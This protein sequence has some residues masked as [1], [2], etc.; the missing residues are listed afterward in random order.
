[1]LDELRKLYSEIHVKILT[2][3][4]LMVTIVVPIVSIR[5]FNAIESADSSNI[6]KGTE[7]VRIIKDRYEDYKGELSIDTLNR[8][9]NYYQSEPSEDLAYVDSSIRYPG[10]IS[11]LMDAYSSIIPGEGIHLNDLK[12]ADDFYSR[13]TV[14]IMG[15]LNHSNDTYEPWE[16]DVILEK[17]ESI[18]TPFNIDFS[19]QWVFAYKLLSVIFIMIFL[20]AIIIG[21]R[22]FSYE[23]EKNMDLILATMSNKQLINIGKN[24]VLALLTFL[25]IKYAISITVLSIIFFSTT[26]LSA[27]SSQI[28]IEYFT[29]IY[30]LT[31]GSAY[32]LFIF[33]GWISTIAIGVLVAAVDAFTQKSYSTLVIGFII[34]FSPLIITR[35]NAIPTFVKRFFQI[36]PV[37][38]LLVEK[39]ISSFQI[40]NVILFNILTTTA[41]IVNAILLL[42]VGM[43]IVPR[44][45]SIRIKNR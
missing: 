25:T 1:M 43:L 24:K 12:N 18:E 23:K 13:N 2:L 42:I 35:L 41:I 28:Q 4:I 33:M 31:L 39:S 17:A 29:S 10:I 15:F 21:S 6:I 38:G 11:I 44:L 40:Y 3:I 36:Q 27:W 20:S 37:N 7:A 19:R 14:Q 8:V 22:I 45:F 30:N 5:S 26:G 32:L 9:L 34:V 16:K